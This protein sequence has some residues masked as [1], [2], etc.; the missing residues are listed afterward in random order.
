LKDDRLTKWHAAYIESAYRELDSGVIGKRMAGLG[1]DVRGKSVLDVGCGPGAFLS[2]ALTDEAQRVVGLEPNP[3]FLK[4]ARQEIERRS[5]GDFALIA[6][7]ATRLPFMD[8]AFDVATC[9]LVL[10]HVPSD[11]AALT[12]LARTLKTGGTLAISG[13]GL[14]FP[15]RYLSRLRFRSLLMYLWTLIYALTG[16]KPV[17]NTLQNYKWICRT[18]ADI[19]LVVERVILPRKR[20]GLVETFRIKAVKR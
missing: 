13:H 9:F 10:P 16:K 14:G 17:R 6:G 3:Q 5:R 2:A 1:L 12:E 11:R 20:L 15:L 8:A 7:T 19:G 4:V 18:L